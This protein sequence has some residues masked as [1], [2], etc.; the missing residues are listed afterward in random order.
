[1]LHKLI[2]KELNNPKQYQPIARGWFVSVLLSGMCILS[3][4][5]YLIFK[6][7]KR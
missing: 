6:I 4:P 5:F 2:S 3:V 7:F 1:M